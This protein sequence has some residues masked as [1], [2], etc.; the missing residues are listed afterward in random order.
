MSDTPAVAV[1]RPVLRFHGGKFRVGRRI[2]AQFPPHERYIEPFGGAA[3]VLM[4]KEPTGC[5]VYND[6]DGQLV[7]VFRVLRDPKL[8]RKLKRAVTLTPYSRR[9]YELSYEPSDDDV[10][11]ARRTLFRSYAAFGGTGERRY[12]T[13]MR[14]SL[15]GRGN[16]PE[17]DW[18]GWP[19]HVKAFTRRLSYVM[20]ENSPAL[21]I[22]NRYDRA[23]TL[24][25]C[26]PPYVHSVRTMSDRWGHFHYA[27][28]MTD[29]EHRLLVARLNACESPV[30]LSG[31]RCALYDELLDAWARVDYHTAINGGGAR[32]ESLWLKP[33]GAL[34]ALNDSLVA[35]HLDLFTVTGMMP[36]LSEE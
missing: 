1:K 31:Y 17:L 18:R 2:I 23:D 30:V 28:E 24:L 35:P 5:D 27:H 14:P 34:A 7:N 25:Y 4:Q 13:G 20:I 16:R 10:E 22:I 21:T 33:A 29:A 19:T 32:V 36:T 9:E 15:G 6:L 26:D 3:S 8:A 12:R 11:Q